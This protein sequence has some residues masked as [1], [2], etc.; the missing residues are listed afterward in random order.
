LSYPFSPTFPREVRSM[1]SSV[2]WFFLFPSILLSQITLTEV[3]FDPLG[4]EATDEFVEVFNTSQLD[5]IDLNGWRLGDESGTDPIVDAGHGLLLHPRQVAVI[6]DPDYFHQSTSYDT[7]IPPDALVI[8]VEGAN[9]GSGGLSNSRSETVIL[10]DHSGTAVGC[11]AYHIG[12]TPGHSDEKLDVFG[13]DSSFNW[14]DSYV[15]LGTPGRKNSVGAE[16]PTVKADLEANPNPFSPDGDGFDDNVTI[17]FRL[18]YRSANVNMR[19]FDI[20]GRLIRHLLA[21]AAG[22]GEGQIRWDGRDDGGRTVPLGL[23][24]LILD[25]LNAPLGKASSSKISIVVAS[26]L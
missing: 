6:L 20:Q 10:L 4:S 22:L 26:P 25:C 1:S 12:N 24:V 5:T 9:L 19:I 8:T 15:V 11:Y 21:G 13:P 2:F 7:L 17:S 18:P 16:D 14:R 3:L 23:Y